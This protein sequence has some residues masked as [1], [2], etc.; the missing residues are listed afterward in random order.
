MKKILVIDDDPQLR[1]VVTNT[2]RRHD[3]EVSEAG[4]GTAGLAVAFQLLPDLILSDVHMSGG[5][6]LEMLKE[7]RAHVETLTIPV[8]LMTGDLQSTTGRLS[9]DMGADDFLTKPFTVEQLMSAVRARLQRQ[10]SISL[11]LDWQYQAERIG[12]EEKLHLQTSAL[13]AAANGIYI[14]DRSGS[15]IWVNRAFTLLTGFSAEDA[16]GRNSRILKSGQHSPKFYANLWIT[17]ST[18]NVWQGELVNRRKDGSLYFEE[19]TITPVRGMDGEIQNYIAIKQD[20]SQR[21]QAEQALARE[22]DRLQ[23]LMDNLPDFIYFKDASR[24]YTCINVALARSLGLQKPEEAIGKTADDFFTTRQAQ[25]KQFNEENLLATGEPILG[26]VEQTDTVNGPQ[27]VSATK[28]PIYGADGTITGL[29][30]ISRDITAVKEAERNRQM[31]EVQLRQAQKLESVGQLAA[32][33]AHEINTPMQYV[34]DNTRFVKESFADL[35]KVLRGYEELLA[36]ART[37]RITPEL[38]ERCGHILPPGDLEYFCEQIPV[39]IE[40]TLEGV[41]R[42]SKIIRAMKEFS[43]PGGKAKAPAN[44]NQAIESTVTVARNEWK[45]V[46]EV[47]LELE[48]KLPAVPCFLGEINQCILNLV[49]NAAHA[50]GDVVKK[51]PGTKGLITVQSRQVEDHAEVRVTDT[52]TGIAAADRAKIFEPFFTTKDVGKGTGQGLALIYGCVVNRHG[53]TVTF[54]TEVGRGT[55]FVIRL[56]LKPKVEVELAPP[57][58]AEM[59]A[60]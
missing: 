36:A 2:L 17:I 60:A 37:G 34:G 58:P 41:E 54:E 4:G 12:A 8:I 57:L 22:R 6:G 11:T 18:G 20:I 53:G 26:R 42:V 3:Y 32:G 31:M 7:L 13:E 14:T 49:V 23:T 28:V 1:K 9:M 30:G 21:K 29:V 40:Q 24:R 52:G 43:H 33:I 59:S 56:P 19:M 39:A 45:Y 5:D 51:Q 46:A 55:T 16:V 38:L 48:P 27:W 15:I 44:L 25:Q 10:E 47:K 35:R 50:I